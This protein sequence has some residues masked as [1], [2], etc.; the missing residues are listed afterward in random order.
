[1]K[2]S[3]IKSFLLLAGLLCL[4]STA[5][6]K[7]DITI[8]DLKLYVNCEEFI[9]KGMCYNPVPLG[10]KSM[11]ADKT[12]GG[13]YC[14][15]KRTPFGEWKSACFDSDFFDGSAD[16]PDRYPAG[17]AVGWFQALWDRDFPVMKE[18]GINTLRLYNANPI[19]RQASIEQK[20]TNGIVEALG[21]NHIPFMDKAAEYGFK[22]I[23]PLM[24]DQTILT[25]RTETE[26]KQFL[27]NQIDEVGNHSALLVS[28]IEFS[29]KI[30]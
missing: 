17:P 27:K 8:S 7:N 1:M 6:G 18:L 2:I 12:G 13:G 11:N 4:A 19:T 28:I 3:K 5:L 22:V 14:S 23:F 24:G 29:Y 9:I 16:I 30:S 26:V 21:K 15:I 10:W 20:G 25:S